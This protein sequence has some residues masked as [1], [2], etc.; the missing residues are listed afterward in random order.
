LRTVFKRDGTITAGNSSK[1]C[2]GGNALILA[3]K[4]SLKRYGLK[5]LAKII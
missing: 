1:I 3:N 4:N 2:D 5:P